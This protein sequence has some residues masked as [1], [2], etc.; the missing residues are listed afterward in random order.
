METINIGQK[1]GKFLIDRESGKN[2][3]EI[4]KRKIES[5]EQGEKIN[6]DFSE[7]VILNPSFCDE[8]FGNLVNEYPAEVLIKNAN[9]AHKVA[10]ETVEETRGVKFIYG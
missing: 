6:M 10:F 9:H 7:V 3:Y 1:F 5:L 8:V 4:L 2:V